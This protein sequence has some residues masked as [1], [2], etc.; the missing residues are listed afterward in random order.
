MRAF[1]SLPGIRYTRVRD[2]T[3]VSFTR[4]V[5]KSRFAKSAVQPTLVRRVAVVPLLCSND[6][7]QHLPGIWRYGVESYEYNVCVACIRTALQVAVRQT[8][9]NGVSPTNCNWADRELEMDRL[10]VENGNRADREFESSCCRRKQRNW[11]TRGQPQAHSP[12][13]PRS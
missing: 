4:I 6:I 1:L 12:F 7:M 10:T 3:Y 8:I 13:T 11:C 5:P 9:Q 2:V